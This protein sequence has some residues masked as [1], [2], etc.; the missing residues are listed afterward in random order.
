MPS[1]RLEIGFHK[2][3][4]K[5]ILQ[6]NFSGKPTSLRSQPALTMLRRTVS[7]SLEIISCMELAQ[8]GKT[9]RKQD[10]EAGRQWCNPRKKVSLP[11][12]LPQSN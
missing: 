4:T 10:E 6:N 8:I 11:L 1:S 12:S 5:V 9:R 2:H 3:T 7:I